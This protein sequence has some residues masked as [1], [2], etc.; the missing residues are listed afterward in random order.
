MKLFLNRSGLILDILNLWLLLIFTEVLST[1]GNS[2]CSL[3]SAG[4]VY[5]LA[6][7]MFLD[8]YPTNNA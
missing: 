5:R 6:T 7:H 3:L 4:I 1:V 8:P 2:L